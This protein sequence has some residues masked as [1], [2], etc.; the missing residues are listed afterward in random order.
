MSEEDELR[1]EIKEVWDALEEVRVERSALVSS[2]DLRESAKRIRDLAH[3]LDV[4]APM[5]GR[6][7]LA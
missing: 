1:A 3:T 6:I 2:R 5:A 7:K 4:L